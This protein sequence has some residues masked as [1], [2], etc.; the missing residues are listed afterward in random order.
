MQAFRKNI[1]LLFFC[2]LT[3][4]ACADVFDEGL[5]FFEENEPEK[6][7]PLLKSACN[8]GKHPEA[9]N[10]LAIAYLQTGEFQK[11][12]DICSLGMNSKGTDKKL[13]SYHAGN[14][15]FHMGNFSEAEKWYTKALVADPAYSAPLLNRANAKLNEN[16]YAEAR[17]DYIKY[18][19]MEADDP[20]RPQIE[21]IIRLLEEKIA[22]DQKQEEE[23]L[24][25]QKR[26]E[27]QEA[28]LKAEEERLKAEQIRLAEEKAEKER[29]AR[30]EAERKAEE[31][32]LAREE[33]ERKAEEERAKK[34]MEE[35]LKKA[36]EERLAREEAERLARE[37]AEKQKKLQEELEEALKNAD[38]TNISAGAEGTVDYGYESELE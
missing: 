6:A 31:E 18:L 4:F 5:K 12:L 28:R 36:E 24:A 7:I 1:L 20:Q 11:G 2:L 8:E 16:K 38:T 19:E 30:E 26:I 10:Y 32:R 37:A 29:I 13:L 23:R 35:A 22:D 14:L 15:C 27:E 17:E 3:S 34:A 21:E 9:F 33:A 25:Q